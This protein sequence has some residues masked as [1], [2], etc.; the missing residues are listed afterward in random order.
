MVWFF[1]VIMSAASQWMMYAI[2]IKSLLYT[3]IAGSGEMLVLGIL[4][5]LTL[6]PAM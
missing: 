1:R 3:V 5:G 4:Y 2:P 6:H